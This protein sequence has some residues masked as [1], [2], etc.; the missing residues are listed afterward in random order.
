MLKTVRLAITSLYHLIT[1]YKIKKYGLLS[2]FKIVTR[3][4][5][6]VGTYAG[7]LSC[8]VKTILFFIRNFVFISHIWNVGVFIPKKNLFLGKARR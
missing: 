1:K 4:Y 6:T 8:Y 3:F 7:I 5:G 2:S